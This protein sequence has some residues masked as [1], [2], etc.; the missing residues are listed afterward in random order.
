MFYAKLYLL[1]QIYK[2][3]TYICET[4]AKYPKFL[5][6]FELFSSLVN[7]ADKNLYCMSTQRFSGA[8]LENLA[9]GNLQE[10]AMAIYQGYR[11]T[12]F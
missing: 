7:V 9:S 8:N 10:V 12:K 5:V 11:D 1:L 4:L 6:Y 2:I 3:F